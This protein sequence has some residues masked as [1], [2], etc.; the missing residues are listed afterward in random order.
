M[1][2]VALWL[3]IVFMLSVYPIKTAPLL[4]HADKLMHFIIYAITCALLFSTL[5]AKM[6]FRRAIALSVLLSAGYGLLLEAIQGI[7]GARSFSLMD[8]AAN[9]A[10]AISAGV[11]IAIKRKGK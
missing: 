5:V 11:Y 9:I 10:G 1:K 2:T 4:P 8:E 3:V 6:S 7:T